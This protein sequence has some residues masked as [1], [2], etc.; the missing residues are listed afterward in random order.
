MPQRG[1]G[2]A[3]NHSLT[4]F[5]FEADHRLEELIDRFGPSNQPE[6]EKSTKLRTLTTFGLRLR[7]DPTSAVGVSIVVGVVGCRL[8]LLSWVLGGRGRR[9][10]RGRSLLHL[11]DQRGRTVHA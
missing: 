5:R 4:A 10:F 9:L 3:V 6:S 1:V 2:A 11:S 8:D 7:I